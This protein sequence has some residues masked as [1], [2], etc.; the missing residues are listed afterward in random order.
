VEIDTVSCMEPQDQQPIMSDDDALSLWVGRVARAHALL[1][2]SVDNVRRFLAL[3]MGQVTESKSVK[4]FDQLASECRGLLQQ[5]NASRDI[6]TSGDAALI[7]A[8]QATAVR[9]RVVHDMW[10]PDS[11]REDWE[12]PRWNVFCRSG[13]IQGSYHSA[14][15][16]DL[17]TIV[18]AH[19]SLGRARLR[20]S[21]LFMALHATWP[22]GRSRV[23]G[24][25]RDDNMA[26]Y[27]ALMN[28]R[29]I[30]HANGDFDVT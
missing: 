1:E 24:S 6:L 30:L 19:T 16:H 5:S 17:A 27:L 9:N 14:S 7:A 15:S 13:D 10:L 3:Q 25:E 18:A 11:L 29:F 2:Y 8:K 21:G 12:L 26:T 20:V 4:G 23:D 28:D 22:T